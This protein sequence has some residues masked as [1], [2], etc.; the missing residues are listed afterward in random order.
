MEEEI[1]EFLENE[2]HIDKVLEFKSEILDVGK[3]HIKCEI[4][5]NGYALGR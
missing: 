4:E 3:Y 2:K 5:F 1:I